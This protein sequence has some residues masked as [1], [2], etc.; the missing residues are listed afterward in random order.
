MPDTK[1]KAPL[2][3]DKEDKEE[4]GDSEEYDN[5]GE[6]EYAPEPISPFLGTEL[7]DTL[8]AQYDLEAEED[9]QSRRKKLLSAVGKRAMQMIKAGAEVRLP[10]DRM[11]RETMQSI[12]MVPPDRESPI[13]P[14]GANLRTPLTYQARQTLHAF[15]C[16]VTT[17]V[18]PYFTTEVDRS[19]DRDAANKV[20]ELLDSYLTEHMDWFQVQDEAIGRALDEG[21]C[22]LYPYWC[23]EKA[24]YRD[25]N[26]LTPENAKSF[27]FKLP[28]NPQ[29]IRPGIK[30]RHLSG[31]T[32][33]LGSFFDGYREA[34]TKNCPEVKVISYFDYVQFPARCEDPDRAT[35]SGYKEYVTIDELRHG[36]KNGL[37]D[38]KQ[39]QALE[40]DKRFRPIT[41]DNRTNIHFD[42]DDAADWLDEEEYEEGNESLAN[43]QIKTPEPSRDTQRV[44]EVVHFIM[45]FDGNGDNLEEDWLFTGETSTSI[46][47]RGQEVIGPPGCRPWR[48]FTIF[49]RPGKLYG[50]PLGQILEGLQ[51]ESDVSANLALDAGAINLTVIVEEERQSSNRVARQTIR[52]GLN[53]RL[54]DEFNKM[55]VHTFP[56][57]TQD[58][59][60][61]GEKIDQ[62]AEKATAISETLAGAMGQSG[63][64][65]ATE[66]QTAVA[67]GARRLKVGSKRIQSVNRQVA[68][69]ILADVRRYSFLPGDNGRVPLA[70][71]Y[72]LSR[73]GERIYGDINLDEL[74]TPVKI[75]AHG[76]T[77]NTNEQLK[78][79]GAEKV[80]MMKERSQF[81]NKSQER[82]YN[83]ERSVLE[84]YGVR[85]IRSLLGTQQDARQEDVQNAQ[86]PPPQQPPLP[87][88]VAP[89][90]LAAFLASNPN[91]APQILQMLQQVYTAQGKGPDAENNVEEQMKLAE[92]KIQMK[93]EM[94]RGKTQIAADKA[95]H[96]VEMAHMKMKHGLEKQQAGLEMAADKA[97]TNL[98]MQHAQNQNQIATQQ[99]QGEADLQMQK[100]AMNQE[101]TMA[102]QK[103]TGEHEMQRLKL[104]QQ[105]AKAKVGKPTMKRRQ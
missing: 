56:M 40:D 33:T 68:Y 88:N 36:V 4:K 3:E 75:F 90:F 22:F 59:F 28:T 61:Q 9:G 96:G 87:P 99:A 2:I 19:E 29:M 72:A 26:R 15:Y 51:E 6:G 80:W 105:Q 71:N 35:L 7:S 42:Q 74:Y 94:E 1:E 91:L 16:E 11:V 25:Y 89:E 97:E 48:A 46:L 55:Q 58:A 23:R 8:K 77:I 43:A 103:A 62:Y 63:D 92:Q 81:I 93:E 45:R 78:L 38:G 18:R 98:Q 49:E 101:Q 64:K 41:E 13:G 82:A 66:A 69:S 86:N 73:Y 95:K 100:T 37:Y 84:S 104:S 85:N 12:Y 14:D 21:T 24:Y 31:K 53:H 34:V 52:T 102:N 17:G 10:R 70:M 50:M 60:L 57:P 79:Q 39:L 44:A 27:G 83:A 54:V 67:A 47:L 65:T 76:D 5:E 20:E 32:A 30:I